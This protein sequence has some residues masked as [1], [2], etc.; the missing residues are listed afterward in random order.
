MSFR[1]VLEEE[2]DI[3]RVGYSLTVRSVVLYVQATWVPVWEETTTT[4]TTTTAATTI[5]PASSP[6]HLLDLFRPT[7]FR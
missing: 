7:I 5:K 6:L 3:D 2:K 1:F 4:T